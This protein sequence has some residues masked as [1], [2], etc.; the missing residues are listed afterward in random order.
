MDTREETRLE[1]RADLYFRTIVLPAD[2]LVPRGNANC[3]G[4][5]TY[6][7]QKLGANCRLFTEKAGNSP[8]PGQTSFPG[9]FGGHSVLIGPSLSR[10]RLA[11]IR[12]AEALDGSSDKSRTW[13]QPTRLETRTEESSAYASRG[14][15]VRELSAKVKAT[16]KEL[17]LRYENIPRARVSALKAIT[18]GPERW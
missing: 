13:F 3:R 6:R 8:V 14:Y 16:T 10:C 11:Q 15:Y 12:P 4:S 18:L 2:R 5:E 1:A 17:V 7:C 9:L